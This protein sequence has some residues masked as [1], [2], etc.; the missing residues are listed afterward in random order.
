V[1]WLMTLDQGRVHRLRLFHP[2]PPR[3]ADA[4]V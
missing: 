4:T 3:T 1:A 2:R